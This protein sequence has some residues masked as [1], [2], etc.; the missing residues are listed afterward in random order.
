LELELAPPP[1][2]DVNSAKDV[3]PDRGR[4]AFDDIPLESPEN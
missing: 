3:D 4:R 1:T 2:P